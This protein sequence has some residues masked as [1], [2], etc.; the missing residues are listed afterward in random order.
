MFEIE[1]STGRCIEDRKDILYS[2]HNNLLSSRKFRLICLTVFCLCVVGGLFFAVC[3]ASIDR[4][5]IV[6][7]LPYY[8]LAPESE[9]TSA[10]M[11]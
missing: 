9:Q 1:F 8:E 4:G 3:W 11:V 5:F 6:L 2:K 10:Y 7:S